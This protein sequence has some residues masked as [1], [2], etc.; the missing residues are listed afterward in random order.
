MQLSGN[1]KRT[2]FNMSYEKY[3]DISKDVQDKQG[4]LSLGEWKTDKK[5]ATTFRRSGNVRPG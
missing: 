2:G 5:Q 4:H 3:A 1:S